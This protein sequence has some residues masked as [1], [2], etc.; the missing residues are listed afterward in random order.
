M[1]RT[2]CSVPCTQPLPGPVKEE[3]TVLIL[4]GPLWVAVLPSLTS[5]CPQGPPGRKRKPLPTLT[6]RV[7]GCLFVLL[8]TPGP[9]GR[10]AAGAPR[11]VPGARHTEVGPGLAKLTGPRRSPRSPRSWPR[12][13]CEWVE[14]LGW[15]PRSPRTPPA[16]LQHAHPRRGVPSTL[17]TRRLSNRAL[18]G[19][20]KY[21]ALRPQVTRMS[22]KQTRSESPGFGSLCVCA[23]RPRPPGATRPGTVPDPAA[24]GAESGNTEFQPCSA[25][26]GLQ[27]PP[28]L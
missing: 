8:R 5:A 23:G 4:L 28:P 1:R 12:E 14:R 7:Q 24:P 11:P 2:P 17:P 6:T 20:R 22:R 27:K 10:A 19:D 25:G 13:A 18:T 3:P 9:R 16:P 26:P 21:S 15:G